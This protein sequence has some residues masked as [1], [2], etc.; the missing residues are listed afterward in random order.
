M[1]KQ[2]KA[3]FG[4]ASAISSASSEEL[5]EKPLFTDFG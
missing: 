1:S 5:P 4:I 2:C 3:M